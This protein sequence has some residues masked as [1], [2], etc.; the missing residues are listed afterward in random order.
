M[1]KLQAVE[2]NHFFANMELLYW[3]KNPLYN[4]QARTFLGY[5]FRTLIQLYRNCVYLKGLWFMIISARNTV[6]CPMSFYCV[7]LQVGYPNFRITVFKTHLS[8]FVSQFHCT[9]MHHV[10]IFFIFL[11]VRCFWTWYFFHYIAHTVHHSFR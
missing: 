5:F 7:I 9:Y 1:Q 11:C 3:S 8:I 4:S 10:Y 2:F 6:S